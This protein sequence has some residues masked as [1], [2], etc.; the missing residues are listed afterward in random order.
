MLIAGMKS[1][2]TFLD[3][4][5]GC[6]GFSLGLERAGL[7]CLA[8]VDFNP[9]AIRVYRANFP[10]LQHVLQEDLVKYDPE[11][12]AAL[13]GGHSVDVIV[14][15]PPCQ[16]FSI[17]RQADGSNS[18]E[19]IVED[20]R[21]HLYKQF[22][23]YVAHF[24]PKVFVMEN[25]L[26][27]R[28]AADGEYYAR[29]QKEARDLGYRVLP[30]AEDAFELGVPQKRRR[31]LFIGTRGD[32]PHYF[33]D[34]LVRPEKA[35][36]HPSLWMAIGDL[37]ALAAGTGIEERDYPL[38]LRR[39]Y[40]RQFGPGYLEGVLEVGRSSKLTAHVARPHSDR[41]LG[42]FAKLYEGE[43]SK[44]AML[45]GVEFDFP[46]DKEN[47][48]DRYTR[49]HRKEPCSTIVA[50]MS[51]DGLMFI[52][53]TQNR[54]LTAREAARVQSFPDWFAFPVSRTQQ[55][56]LIGNAVPPLVGEAVGN[57]VT[58]YLKV[59]LK[60][61]EDTTYRFTS[62]V[63]MNCD[64]ALAW[65][66]ELVAVIDGKRL[67]KLPDEDFKRGWF[68]IGYWYPELHPDGALESGH[69]MS[70]AAA[71]GEKLREID[72]RL[73]VPFYVQSGWPVLLE[74]VARE[75]HRRY[76]AGHLKRHELYPTEAAIAG[77]WSRRVEDRRIQK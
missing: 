25:V 59:A 31:Q 47:F 37:P 73:V 56:R 44:E 63:P 77:M 36:A 66:R 18:G 49:Q 16:G 24:R 48:K 58:N 57:V 5:C 50:H 20:K 38:G 11:T 61:T 41:D 70:S 26:G 67:R 9:D 28:S 65:L 10:N 46:Y 13:I 30:K 4:F 35:C 3:L 23:R 27:I 39:R 29:V 17:S 1:V 71:N 22:L 14:G 45:R 33:I 2:I 68:S 52:H 40:L 15:G 34:S 54:S 55:F 6:G 12:L 62:P 76:R 69:R 53:P 8:A 7:K 72:A 74:P 51:K 19:R 21:R 43:N 60:P 64:Q 75:A 32:L 42:D